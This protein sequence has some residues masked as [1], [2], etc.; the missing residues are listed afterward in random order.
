MFYNPGASAPL[1][2]V[3]SLNLHLHLCRQSLQPYLSFHL[4]V[5]DT[6]PDTKV[7]P[8]GV[9]GWFFDADPF[10]LVLKDEHATY[11]SQ[12]SEQFSLE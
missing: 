9:A 5:T 1:S 10:V 12:A 7:R 2:F 4:L 11:S 8:H 6:L 3:F